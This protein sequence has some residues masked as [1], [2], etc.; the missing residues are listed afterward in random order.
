MIQVIMRKLQKK[1]MVRL[2]EILDSKP[3]TSTYGMLPNLLAQ[4]VL[5][6]LEN[7]TGF[8]CSILVLDHLPSERESD[9]GSML[10]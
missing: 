1:T 5:Q 8:T 2:I 3:R 10:A 6:T 7:A 4:N 9:N